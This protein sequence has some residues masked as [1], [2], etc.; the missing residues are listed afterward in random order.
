M[1]RAAIVTG[2]TAFDFMTRTPGTGLWRQPILPNR[3]FL[4]LKPDPDE[5]LIIKASAREIEGQSGRQARYIDTDR[6]HLSLL[7]LGDHPRLPGPLVD[8]IRS[9][10]LG[11]EIAAPEIVFNRVSHF[12]GGAV[13]L[14]NI[15]P[16]HCVETLRRK[17]LGALGAIPIVRLVNSRNFAPHLTLFYSNS[18]IREVAVR[19]IV[20]RAQQLQLVHSM[21]GQSR[22]S[23][24]ASWPLTTSGFSSVACAHPD[25]FERL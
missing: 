23:T 9:L 17:L 3:L 14:R 15:K 8:R 13:V 24:L 4:A 1:T 25:L 7:S 16:L 12:G 18:P 11:I 20:W 10:V 21:V 19:P 5:A 6:L 22:H 2:Q